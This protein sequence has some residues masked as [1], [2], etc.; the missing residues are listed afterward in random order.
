MFFIT[1]TDA[2]INL[3]NCK[4]SYGS[5]ILISS[6]GT[7]EWGKSGSNGGNVTL[8]AESQTLEGDIEIDNISTLTMNL[9]SSCYTGTINADNS[10]KSIALKL[11]TNSSITLTGDSYVTSLEDSDSSYSNINFNG[12]KLY[13]GGEK[14]N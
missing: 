2:V 4:L 12:Y 13:V 7:S 1:N 9:I 10:A 6:K 11:D 5:N 3:N 14:I 8:N